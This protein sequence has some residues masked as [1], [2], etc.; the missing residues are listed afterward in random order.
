MA[1]MFSKSNA[2][3]FL[4][5]TGLAMQLLQPQPHPYLWMAA[6]GVGGAPLIS[7]V[8]GI[9]KLASVQ[10]RSFENNGVQ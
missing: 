5:M 8:V 3:V 10:A 4:T 9:G 6:T 2:F 7:D 1:P